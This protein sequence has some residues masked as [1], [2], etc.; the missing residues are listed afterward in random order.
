MTKT[1]TKF[2]YFSFSMFKNKSFNSLVILPHV[3]P[4][5]K[6]KKNTYFNNWF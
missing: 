4:Q 6:E 1:E 2:Q 5:L 3:N